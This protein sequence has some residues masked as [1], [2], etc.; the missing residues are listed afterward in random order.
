MFYKRIDSNKLLSGELRLT[1]FPFLY[2]P[3]KGETRGNSI[4]LGYYASSNPVVLN[5]NTFVTKSSL[6][7]AIY[8]QA[9]DTSY[10]LT[11]NADNN[12]FIG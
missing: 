10:N 4:Y 11:V 12:T 3:C 8:L 7:G 9:H 2:E 6:G 5:G 1:A